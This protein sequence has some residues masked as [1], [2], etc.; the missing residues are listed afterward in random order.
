M[1]KFSKSVCAKINQHKEIDHDY[2]HI[3]WTTALTYCCSG[4]LKSLRYFHNN[5]SVFRIY[6]T[7]LSRIQFWELRKSLDFHRFS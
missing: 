7:F 1:F 4:Q 6:L 3:I 2:F 5:S